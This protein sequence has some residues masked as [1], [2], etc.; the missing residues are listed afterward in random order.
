MRLF[1]FRQ[2]GFKNTV[3]IEALKWLILPTIYVAVITFLVVFVLVTPIAIGLPFEYSGLMGI[4]DL[5]EIGQIWI[6]MATMGAEYALE[7]ALIPATLTGV[8]RIG[9]SVYVLRKELLDRSTYIAAI[10][11]SAL[12]AMYFSLLMGWRVNL[13]YLLPF[14]VVLLVFSG[15]G[16]VCCWLTLK[17][18]AR[19]SR[20]YQEA[21]QS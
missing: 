16:V 2:R 11:L 12:A 8:T 10:G 3:V 1:G 7:I 15:T 20:H 9:L 17:S 21:G 18:N 4:Q 13:T 6:G 19:T 14:L 5:F